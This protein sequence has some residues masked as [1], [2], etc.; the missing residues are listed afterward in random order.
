[1]TV[2]PLFPAGA[3]VRAVPP[4]LS[5]AERAALYAIPYAGAHIAL[6]RATFDY[7]AAEAALRGLSIPDLATLLLA[8][9]ARDRGAPALLD[10]EPAQTHDVPPPTPHRPDPPEAT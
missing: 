3:P 1:M 5:A 7:L 2:V 4:G 10:E 6:D 8:G 9:V